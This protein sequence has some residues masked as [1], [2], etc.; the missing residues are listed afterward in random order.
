MEEKICGIVSRLK[1]QKYILLVILLG[2]ALLLLPIGGERKTETTEDIQG[3]PN[4]SLEVEEARLCASVQA[5]E[6]VEA[7]QVLLALESTAERK[8]AETA[9]GPLV[10]SGGNSGEQTV[11]LHYR[12]PEYRG[13][14]VLWRGNGGARTQLDITQVTEAFTGLSSDKITVK[15]MEKQ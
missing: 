14:V 11:E 13:A 8:L 6:G 7:A 15:S 12:Y 3:Q 1:G 9:E 10:V 4:F 5:L 2:L